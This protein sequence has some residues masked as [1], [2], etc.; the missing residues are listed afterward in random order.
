MAREYRHR[1]EPSRTI[2]R[3]GGIYRRTQDGAG[4]SLLARSHHRWSEWF[5]GQT[6][7]P[8]KREG[9]GLPPGGGQN[10]A[11]GRSEGHAEPKGRNEDTCKQQH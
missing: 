4:A 1:T 2:R 11:T 9:G 5:A 6:D 7:A 3:M 8:A 10:C